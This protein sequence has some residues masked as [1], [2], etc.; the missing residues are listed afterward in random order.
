MQMFHGFTGLGHP[1][2]PAVLDKG[3]GR[4]DEAFDTAFQEA[5]K[6]A[7]GGA[8]IVELSELDRTMDQLR[9]EQEIKEGREDNLTDF[10]RYVYKL[11]CE[12]IGVVL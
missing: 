8:T 5:E 1:M 7:A 4:A 10:Q 11:S 3:K 6:A 9:L 12:F 2:N